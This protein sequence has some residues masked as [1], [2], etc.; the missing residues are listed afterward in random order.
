M[1][2]KSS[3][4]RKSSKVSSLLQNEKLEKVNFN[5][6]PILYEIVTPSSCKLGDFE[7]KIMKE[8]LFLQIVAVFCLTGSQC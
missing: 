6:F 1:Q 5:S 4:L 7:A 3:S 2:Q 8:N